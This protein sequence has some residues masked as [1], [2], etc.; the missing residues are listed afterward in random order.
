ML[1][2]EI[3]QE[4]KK[5]AFIMY[6]PTPLL[7]MHPSSTKSFRYGSKVLSRS[8]EIGS[9]KAKQENRSTKQEKE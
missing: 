7:A 3:K 1:D 8:E 2:F 6:N 4:T 5:K 9:L